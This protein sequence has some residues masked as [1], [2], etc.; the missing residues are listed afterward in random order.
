[1]Y[2]YEIRDSESEVIFIFKFQHDS[3]TLNNY[4]HLTDIKL[5]TLKLWI[6]CTSVFK[7]KLNSHYCKQ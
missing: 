1:M 6:V 4:I 7:N 3:Q 5:R 2:Y